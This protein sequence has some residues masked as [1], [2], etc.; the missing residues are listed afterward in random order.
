MHIQRNH[1]VSFLV[2]FFLMAAS[3]LYAEEKTVELTVSPESDTAIGYGDGFEDAQTLVLQLRPADGYYIDHSECQDNAGE[4]LWYQTKANSMLHVWQTYGV[5]PNF[6]AYGADPVELESHA[7]VFHGLLGIIDP[8]GGGPINLEFDVEVNDV[9]IDVD[10]LGRHV[11]AAWSPVDPEAESELSE[12]EDKCE[13]GQ[14]GGMGIPQTESGTTLPPTLL[15]ADNTGKKLR[16]CINAKRAGTLIFMDDQGNDLS[17]LETMYG[18][19]I[20]SHESGQTD[21]L[22]VTNSGISIPE[23]PF[24]DTNMAFYIHT[25]TN[26]TGDINIVAKLQCDGD[27]RGST[28]D[29]VRVYYDPDP[30]G[31]NTYSLYVNRPVLTDDYVP[32]E[33]CGRVPITV[34]VK[35]DS[36]EDPPVA[37]NLKLED[38]IATGEPIKIYESKVGGTGVSSKIFTLPADEDSKT[39]WVSGFW[40]LNNTDGLGPRTLKIYEDDE[41]YVEK[42]FV[43]ITVVHTT[44]AATAAVK[45]DPVSGSNETITHFV[46]PKGAMPN[47]VTLTASI[48]PVGV[49]GPV[50]WVTAKESAGDQL[51]ATVPRNAARRYPVI[52]TIGGSKVKESRVWVL[53]SKSTVDEEHAITSEPNDTENGLVI[54]GGYKIQH[55]I[56]PKTIFTDA[57]RPDLAGANT[58]DPDNVLSTDENVYNK[59][60]SLAGGADHMWDASQKVRQKCLTTGD[61]SG[62]TELQTIPFTTYLNFP[63]VGVCGNDDKTTTGAEEDEENNDPY[64][65]GYITLDDTVSRELLH[66]NGANDATVEM[67]IH[68]KSFPRVQLGD[69]WY[70]IG[71]DLLWRAHL[72][73]KKVDGQWQNNASNIATDNEGFN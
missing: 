28:E 31:E 17:D 48:L 23:G 56:F 71:D 11:D 43:E 39:F 6:K 21:Q 69:H 33:T 5:L 58:V 36:E 72:K 45:I 44:L 40:E 19:A 34:E 24:N 61:V 12:V 55:E 26:F 4:N 8:S 16:V 15:I 53:W 59:S 29:T 30:T 50:D 13:V 73:F 18:M 68:L 35:R 42:G 25:S 54:S 37:L 47:M 64:T 32:D 65:G 20:Y 52:M 38:V 67:R 66:A 9:D 22:K 46:T 63:S 3:C 2:V 60:V 70:R 10:A 49:S 7:A 62:V 1:F 27:T 51:V 41:G 14:N 57:D